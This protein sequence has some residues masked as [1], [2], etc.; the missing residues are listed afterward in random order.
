MSGYWNTLV[1]SCLGISFSAS[2][3]QKTH[4]GWEC[5]LRFA[6]NLHQGW[7]LCPILAEGEGVIQE[8]C[9]FLERETCRQL[10]PGLVQNLCGSVNFPSDVQYWRKFEEQGIAGVT[11][12]FAT[13]SLFRKPSV[14]RLYLGIWTWSP[15][16]HLFP[17]CP[18]SP[19][20]PIPSLCIL[21]PW[22][23]QLSCCFL[24]CHAWDSSILVCSWISY[25]LKLLACPN[26]SQMS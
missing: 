23:P 1:S 17:R 18:S 8:Q 5:I 21:Q 24:S 16:G 12:H 26:F 6:M 13:S 10:K 7:K 9:H 22:A 19:L 4:F 20:H 3:P 11:V 14:L 25:S 2:T 15:P